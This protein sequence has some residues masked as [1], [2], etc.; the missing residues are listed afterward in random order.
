MLRVTHVAR[1]DAPM[2]ARTRLTYAGSIISQ[3]FDR[4][5]SL[6]PVTRH[7]VGL[8]VRLK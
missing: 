8:N 1:H 4:S 5:I 7:G 2:P 6:L 3:V